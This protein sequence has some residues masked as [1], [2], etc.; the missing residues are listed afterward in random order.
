MKLI[1]LAIILTNYLLHAA[2]LCRYPIRQSGPMRRLMYN[3]ARMSLRNELPATNAYANEVSVSNI[4]SEGTDISLAQ[5][6]AFTQVPEP[7]GTPIVNNA[8][9]LSQSQVIIPTNAESEQNEQS[10]TNTV[11]NSF[12]ENRPARNIPDRFL[13]RRP[14]RDDRRPRG[15]AM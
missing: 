9:H 2:S 3:V 12:H 1:T 5:H 10:Q 11:T 14:T 13:T 8:S 7:I 4:Q 6:G 15:P